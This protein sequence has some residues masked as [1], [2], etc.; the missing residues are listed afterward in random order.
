[1]KSPVKL[2]KRNERRSL[3]RR[4]YLLSMLMIIFG[5]M[6]AR[7][8]DEL[9]T[10][11][12]EHLD[13]ALLVEF[14][15]DQTAE[16]VWEYFTSKKRGLWTGP[17]RTIKG[18]SDQAGEIFSYHLVNGDVVYPTASYEIVKVEP[19]KHIVLAMW[20][21]KSKM[22]DRSLFGYDI[23][24][25]EERNGKTKITFNQ[26][27]FITATEV[28]NIVRKMI[29]E[30]TS[31]SHQIALKGIMKKTGGDEVKAFKLYRQRVMSEIFIKLKK[32]IE[33]K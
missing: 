3:M 27:S 14:S 31:S 5:C 6:E 24:N 11:N 26:I 28:K 21:H 20:G 9:D 2:I 15:V 19:F 10:G 4:A 12:G 22:H 30:P 16:E 8:N 13:I 33:D 17:Y 1:M 32:L 18:K 7:G 23:V 29:N 25:I